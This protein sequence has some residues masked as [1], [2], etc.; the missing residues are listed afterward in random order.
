MFDDDSS[1]SYISQVKL[2]ELKLESNIPTYSQIP[3]R[4]QISNIEVFVF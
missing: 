1:D 4:K 2:P 3:V